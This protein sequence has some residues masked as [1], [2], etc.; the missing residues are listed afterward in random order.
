MTDPC[1]KEKNTEAADPKP[2]AKDRLSCCSSPEDCAQMMK[3]CK[4]HL[5]IA[6]G[7][8]LLAGAAWFGGRQLVKGGCP[9]T[10]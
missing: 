4:R 10:G 7:V 5:A 2:E 3:K 6:A 8:A 1:C 9:C